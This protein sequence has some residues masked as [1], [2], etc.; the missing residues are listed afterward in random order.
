MSCEGINMRCAS[1]PLGYSLQLLSYIQAEDYRAAR[2][3]I[4]S[5]PVNHTVTKQQ[6]PKI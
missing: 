6:N 1:L 2:E 5:K 4:S 3:D